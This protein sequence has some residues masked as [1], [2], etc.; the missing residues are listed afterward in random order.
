MWSV[1]ERGCTSVPGP[2]AG[3]GRAPPRAPRSSRALR[4]VY[5]HG[6]RAQPLFCPSSLCPSDWASDGYSVARPTCS[7]GG[8]GAEPTVE[9]LPSAAAAASHQKARG[10]KGGG[11][12]GG[13]V[14][15]SVRLGEASAIRGGAGAGGTRRRPSPGG[16]AGR[17]G[18]RPPRPD[19]QNSGRAQ[20]PS[21]VSRP[22]L[23][24]TRRRRPGGRTQPG[25]PP[26]P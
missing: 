11:E 10:G 20:Q 14:P 25:P 8:K 3:P 9:A 13:G 16:R 1:V 19:P 22:L 6:R 5:G 26:P 7:R 15:R 2:G 12:R 21:R 4:R 18:V 23:W 24:P 17:G